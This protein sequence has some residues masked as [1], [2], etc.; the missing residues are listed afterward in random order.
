MATQAGLQIHSAGTFLREARINSNISLSEASTYLRIRIEYLKLIE[1]GCYEDL[2]GTTY[3]IGFIRSYAKYLGVDAKILIEQYKEETASLDALPGLEFPLPTNIGWFPS[4]KSVLIC[5]F[6]SLFT[7]V[8]WFIFESDDLPR[9]IDIP[10]PPGSAE[11][12]VTLGAH[13]QKLNNASKFMAIKSKDDVNLH[14][15]PKKTNLMDDNGEDKP[16]QEKNIFNKKLTSPSEHIT[17]KLEKPFKINTKSEKHKK[18]VKD[19]INREILENKIEPNIGNTYGE[20]EKNSRI[21]LIAEADSWVQVL[22]NKKNIIISRMF[23]TGDRYNVPNKSGLILLTGNAGGLKITIDGI[24]VP[25]IGSDG[26]IL[27]NVRLDIE[28]LKQGR[29]V[30]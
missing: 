18:D 4:G 19:S 10:L 28:L 27:K 1:D 14:K 22:D 2:P 6:F 20:G 16:N 7:L 15:S 24:R 8:G 13:N 12:A 21:I 25:E 3:A 11:S 9:T 5:V 29:A 17:S 26:A 30:N 23:R